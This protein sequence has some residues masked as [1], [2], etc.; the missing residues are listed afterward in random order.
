MSSMLLPS[1]AAMLL[2]WR[3]TSSGKC[4]VMALV[5]CR[6]AGGGRDGGD[7]D[8][9]SDGSAA[10]GTV[11]PLLRS[12]LSSALGFFITA[13]PLCSQSYNTAC[14][15]VYLL[16]FLGGL[17]AWLGFRHTQAH[18][19]GILVDNALTEGEGADFHP[20]AGE[21]CGRFLVPVPR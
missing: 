19:V 1:S 8:A 20:L 10:V 6:D 4:T 9:G 12:A 3:R 21:P 5:A 15:V 16:Y 17:A 18:S 11:A 7:A 14:I 2:S 13:L